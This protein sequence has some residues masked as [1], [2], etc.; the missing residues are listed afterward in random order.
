MKQVYTGKTKDVYTLDDGNYLL[1]FKDD[2][3]GEDGVFDPGANKVGL[4]IEGMG[5]SNLK[6]SDYYFKKLNAAG[7]PTHY[8]SSDLQKGEMTVLPAKMFGG[9]GIEVIVRYRATGSFMR[10]YGL[11]ATEGQPLDALVEIT[12]KD[13]ER[14]DPLITRDSLDALGI[15]SGEEHD[16]LKKRAQEI[17]GLIKEDLAGKGLELIDIKL[18]FGRV[19]DDGRI[20]LIDEVTSGCMRV[21]KD[22]GKIAPMDLTRLA[23]S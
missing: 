2:V 10:R 1:R 19:G 21:Y 16:I 5:G 9:H 20:A 23:I 4:S 15:L 13:D 12:L 17:C 11:Y 22:G 7:I 6:M 18:E 14:N 8:I 3:T